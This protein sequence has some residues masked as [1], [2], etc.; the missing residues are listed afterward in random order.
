MN[1]EW[2]KATLM[3][4]TQKMLIAKIKKKKYYQAF[5]IEKKIMKI[6][7]MTLVYRKYVQTA[8]IQSVLSISIKKK[9]QHV[10]LQTKTKNC[11]YKRVG[12]KA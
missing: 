7:L 4:G 3:M 8:H 6:K 9:R 5:L 12:K 11:L 1:A 2:D 10:N